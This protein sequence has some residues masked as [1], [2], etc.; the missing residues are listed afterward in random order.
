MV[1]VQNDEAEERE[2]M[3]RY[4]Q[5]VMECVP[6]TYNGYFNMADNRYGPPFLARH[7]V[8]GTYVTGRE[9]DGKASW[10]CAIPV[11]NGV[12]WKE[13]KTFEEK[14]QCAYRATQTVT[15]TKDRT[16]EVEVALTDRMLS[17]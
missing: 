8:T 15:D 1:A 12:R 16:V 11:A 6:N 9:Q 3:H 4:K 17:P 14:V 2:L 10:W 5:R 7:V 13:V